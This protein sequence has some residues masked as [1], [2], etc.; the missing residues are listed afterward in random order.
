MNRI[1]RFRTRIR[2][3]RMERIP[4]IERPA[5]N[6]C[7]RTMYWHRGK[8]DWTCEACDNYYWH[9]YGDYDEPHDWEEGEYGDDDEEYYDDDY[10]PG[11]DDYHG[12][13]IV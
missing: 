9:M 1:R 7:K 5:C 8:Q 13:I 4:E 6:N 11:F 10:P 3:W 12:P 2:N